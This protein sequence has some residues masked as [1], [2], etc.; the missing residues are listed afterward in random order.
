M[1]VFDASGS[2]K[3]NIPL[4]AATAGKIRQRYQS[5][6]KG[7][8]D[9]FSAM[10]SYV[11][12]AANLPARISVAKNAAR[13][14]VGSLPQDVDIGLVVLSDCPSAQSAGFFKPPERFQLQSRI[15]SLQP[16]QGTPLGSAVAKAGNMV[17][18]VDVPGIIVVISDGEESCDADVCGIARRLAAKKPRLV[19]NTV[20]IMG[21]GA[22][23]CL[24]SAT[25][26]R[27]FTASNAQEITDMIQL[28]AS[29]A[30]GP[31]NCSQE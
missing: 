12:S 20:D 8:A 22:G 29:A 28:A 18:G 26:G 16:Y 3:E 30:K 23:D 9:M 21:T 6:N 5:S 17:D 10:L 31:E 27:V 4:D 19:I 1:I 11:V 14:L 15:R 7:A 2:M 13:Q 25:G 24:A